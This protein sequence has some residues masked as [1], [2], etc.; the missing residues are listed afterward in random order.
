ME[1]EW[2]EVIEENGIVYRL[3]ENRC[4]YPDVRLPEGTHYNIVESPN[5]GVGMV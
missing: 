3:A 4:Y 5:F 2:A 1:K